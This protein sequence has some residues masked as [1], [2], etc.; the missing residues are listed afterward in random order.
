[1]Q[2]SWGHQKFRSC[3]N[4]ILWGFHPNGT[5]SS[6]KMVSGLLRQGLLYKTGIDKVRSDIG[7][8]CTCKDIDTGNLPKSGVK[9]SHIAR[10]INLARNVA[11]SFPGNNWRLCYCTA[12]HCSC[13]W[14]FSWSLSM[15]RSEYLAYLLHQSWEVMLI[16]KP[17]YFIAS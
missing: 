4:S 2:C 6:A 8:R 1:M 5:Q 17:L 3:R 12:V 15:Q 14:A 9:D 13:C 7:P 10:I 16:L 11:R